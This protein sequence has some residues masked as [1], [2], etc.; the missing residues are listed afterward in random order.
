VSWSWSERHIEEY[1]RQGY[2]IFEAILPTSLIADLRR[3]CDAARSLARERSGAQTQRL[4]PVFDIDTVPFAAFTQLPAL[5]DALQRTLSPRHTC[6]HEALGVLLEPAEL[7]WCTAWHRDW[8]DNIFGLDLDRWEADLRDVDLFNQLNCALYENGSTWVVPGSHLRGDLPR[9]TARFPD[10]PI[11]GPD[12][13]GLDAVS[14]ER[15]CLQYCA[16][17]T[18]AT[19]LHLAAGDLC[20]IRC[21]ISATTCPIAGG[22]RC[23]TSSTRRPTVPG[24]SGR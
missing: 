18:G 10:R 1:H 17:L 6:T 5:V 3:A 8:R 19:Q 15:S 11:A 21:G 9:E 14:R 4:Q 12:L 7:P 16:S 23:T 13:D 24:V 20:V 22:R 2:T